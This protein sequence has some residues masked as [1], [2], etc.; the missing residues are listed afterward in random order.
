MEKRKRKKKE[1]KMELRL[2]NQSQYKNISFKIGEKVLL[3]GIEI[4]MNKNGSKTQIGELTNKMISG[5]VA[6][7]ELVINC[8]INNEFTIKDEDDSDAEGSRMFLVE[9]LSNG[10]IGKVSPKDVI[11]LDIDKNAL[12]NVLE[13]YNYKFTREKNEIKINKPSSI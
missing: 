10:E 13:R 12:V 1:E 8:I 9:R 11:P 2:I 3:I 4:F 6:K 7:D 5:G